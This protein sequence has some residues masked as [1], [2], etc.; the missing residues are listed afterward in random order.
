MLTF[1][2]AYIG[3]VEMVAMAL[4]HRMFLEYEPEVLDLHTPTW[5]DW[6]RYSLSLELLVKS[7]ES[8]ALYRQGD[9]IPLQGEWGPNDLGTGSS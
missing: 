9:S 4:D 5:S 8:L 2:E 3:E 1:L 7:F 6:L